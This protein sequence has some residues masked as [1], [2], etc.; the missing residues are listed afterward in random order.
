[1]LAEGTM[2]KKYKISLPLKC[3]CPSRISSGSALIERKQEENC[4]SS[5]SSRISDISSCVRLPDLEC[6]SSRSLPVLPNG[7]SDSNISSRSSSSSSISSTS[8]RKSGRRRQCRPP[9]TVK[10]VRVRTGATIA[11]CSFE[12]SRSRRPRPASASSF[13]ITRRYSS[14]AIVL[15]ST[16]LLL[17]HCGPSAFLLSPGWAVLLDANGESTGP[18]GAPVQAFG[19]GFGNFNLERSIAAVFSRVAY[20]STTTTKRSIPDNVYVPSLTTVSTPLLTTFRYREKDKDSLSLGGGSGAGAVE[21]GLGGGREPHYNQQQISANHRNY[22]LDLERDHV[23]PTSAPNAEILKSNS[24]PTYPNPNRH[25]GHDRHRHSNSTP[26]PHG[27][28]KKGFPTNPMFPGDISSYSPPSRAFFTPPLPRNYTNPFADKPTLRGTNSDSTVINTGS[29]VNR[30]PLPPPSLMP[31]HERIPIRPDLNGPVSPQKPSQD[32]ASA[33]GGGS[34]PVLGGGGGPSSSSQSIDQRKKALNTPSEKSSKLDSAKSYG[35]DSKF[36]LDGNGN[37]SAILPNGMHFPSISRILS[38]SNGRTQTIPDV[39]L[40]SV[41]SAPRPN[42]PTFDLNPPVTSLSNA[43]NLNKGNN[44]SDDEG[45]DFEAGN[46]NSS[47]RDD[48]DDDEEDDEVVGEKSEG[49][50]Y[51]TQAQSV[52][53]STVSSLIHLSSSSSP[54]TQKMPNLNLK[55]VMIKANA[56]GD[57]DGQTGGAG[58][59]NDRNF[60]NDIE[61]ISTWTIAWN[62]H[63]YLSAILFTILAVYSIFKIIFYDKLT[64]LFSQSYF[65]SIHLILII[66]CLLRIFYLCYDAYNIHFSFNLFTSELL[67]NLPLTFLTTTFA[68]LILFLLLRSIN[69]KTNRYSSILRPL[70]IMIGSGVHVGLCVTLHLVESYETQQFYHKQA[71]LMASSRGG[72][73]GHGPTNIQIPPRVLSLICQIIYIFI[74]LSLGILYLYMYRLLKRILHKSQNYIHGYNN[75]SYAIHITI[76]TALLFILLAALQIYGAISISS[77]TKVKLSPNN[78]LND[79]SAQKTLWASHIE[80]DWFQWG[81]QF[82]LRFIEIVIIALLSWVTGLKTGTSKVIQREKDMEQPNASG[83]ALFPCTS[84][85]SQ[86]NFETDYP[87][88]CNAN[89]NLHTYTL[90][91]GKPIYDDNFALNS[92]NL[93]QNSNQDLQLGPGGNDFQRSI[94]TNSMRS[95]SHNY[96]NNY[97]GS[98]QAD[99]HEDFMNDS[100]QMPDHYENPNFELKHHHRGEP[101]DGPQYHDIMDNC[102]SEPINAPPY[103]TKSLRG[104]AVGGPPPVHLP[105]GSR[106]YDFQN[107]ERPSFDQAASSQS[108]SRGEFRASKNLKTLKSGQ[109]NYDGANTMGHHHYNH[110]N[111][112]NDSFE[113]RIGVRK[114]GTLNNIGGMHFNQH[115]GGS[116]RNNNNSVSSAS[117]STSSNNRGAIQQQQQQQQQQAQQMPGQG[118][119]PR[120]AGP[121]RHMNGAQTLSTAGGR[122]GPDHHHHHHHHPQAAPRNLPGG[123][124]VHPGSFNDRIVNGHGVDHSSQEHVNNFD[125][126]SSSASYYHS[127]KRSRESSSSSY[128]G[129]NNNG[130]DHGPQNQEPGSSSPTMSA[131]NLPINGMNGGG[132]GGSSS[133][134]SSSGVL[135]GKI[136]VPAAGA[137]GGSDSSSM[138]VAEQGFVRFRALEDPALSSRTNLRDKNKLFMNS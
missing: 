100:E 91:T 32:V 12:P 137:G 37:S 89:T 76:A 31:G 130:S 112:Y 87:A 69:H 131:S 101:P 23:L 78:N 111:N 102:Y 16:V 52:Q 59:G 68:I 79:G 135:P 95:S 121:E 109:A 138:L 3:C 58:Y 22:E 17:C 49:G 40:R 93:E 84:S 46:E 118:R 82:S 27:H 134:G 45:D 98:Q 81:Y 28:N 125:D 86:E 1:M 42:Q 57:G 73:T 105:Q 50:L 106:N 36:M 94:E 54:I 99:Q 26:Y 103:D 62:I 107:F 35:V 136:A 8:S 126:N 123:D 13:I 90:R 120:G 44:H 41:T 10:K 71:Q 75:L 88:V 18:A 122:G 116:G 6:S 115:A 108:I 11:T 127:K 124:F 20:G 25:H 39:L 129:F 43:K 15:I 24:N 97:N 92:L 47:G 38:G 21:G 77:Q 33:V 67:L 119:P 5:L 4:N 96:S 14:L 51:S 74:C 64:H 65:I 7:D 9:D 114:S 66:I 80:I 60:A 128:T 56:S 53:T 34:P 70:T 2:H 110:F 72:Q 132:G 19:D 61:D 63:V 55:S 83:F 29:Y 104:A 133:G 48:E 117:S 30:R 113:R 85:S